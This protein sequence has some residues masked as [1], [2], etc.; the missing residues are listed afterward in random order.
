M[1]D[2]KKIMDKLAEGSDK[3]IAAPETIEQLRLQGLP[4]KDIPSPTIS[5]LFDLRK[6]QA[7][8][9]ARYLPALPEGLSP[10]IQAIYQEIRECIFF[11]CN[12]AAITLSAILIEFMLKR[13]TYE[14]ESGGPKNYDPNIW[15]EFEDMDLSSAINR[16][17][18]A[19]ILNSKMAKRLH[20]FRKEIR[21]PYS[22]YNIQKITEN[23]IAQKVKV[24]NTKTGEYEEKDLEAKDNPFIQSVA[25]PVV[26]K[27]NVL[28]VFH[29]ADEVVKY[30]LTKTDSQ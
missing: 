3:I 30:L 8:Q 26:D 20:S 12:G 4:I 17:K 16:A 6:K 28:R 21:N 7:H 23:V 13:V 19:K 25:K 5:E 27:H 18:R 2:I 22:H 24:L 10:T 29:F 11:G 9:I 14:K 1:K 15:A